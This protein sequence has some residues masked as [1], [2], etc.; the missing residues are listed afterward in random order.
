VGASVGTGEEMRP[1]ADDQRRVTTVRIRVISPCAPSADIGPALIKST[2]KPDSRQAAHIFRPFCP[3][4]D[5]SAAGSKSS[6]PQMRTASRRGI[7]RE[8]NDVTVA[9]IVDDGLP[10]AD[11]KTTPDR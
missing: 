1:F 4:A 5:R 8:L 9:A 10:G 11:R 7:H 6:A 2:A 3:R